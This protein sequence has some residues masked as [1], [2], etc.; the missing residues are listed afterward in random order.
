MNKVNR[1]LDDPINC[2]N[3]KCNLPNRANYDIGSMD[4][5]DFGSEIQRINPTKYTKVLE[6]EN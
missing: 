5:F 3:I 1:R 4:V 2:I 6:L